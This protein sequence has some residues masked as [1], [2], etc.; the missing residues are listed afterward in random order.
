MG[1]FQTTMMNINRNNWRAIFSDR[2]PQKICTWNILS[3]VLQNR[4]FICI[5]NEKASLMR[6]ITYNGFMSLVYFRG[7]YISELYELIDR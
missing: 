5:G 4:R 3:L 1:D 6:I 2:K 7:F